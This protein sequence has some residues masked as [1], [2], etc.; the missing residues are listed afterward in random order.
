VEEVKAVAS[1]VQKSNSADL[2][3][4]VSSVSKEAAAVKS[5]DKTTLVEK[6]EEGSKDVEKD[7]IAGAE[8]AGKE[9]EAH[10]E[11]IAE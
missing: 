1:Q 11:L 6:V 8:S 2:K 3:N 5:E 4:I 7:V 10:P 9:I